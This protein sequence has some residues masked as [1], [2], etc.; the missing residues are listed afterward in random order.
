MS[1]LEAELSSQSE[2]EHN[3]TEKDLA[4]QTS[5][6]TLEPESMLEPE[7][8][9]TQN[10]E[11]EPM[12]ETTP[13]VEVIQNDNQEY[14]EKIQ[15]FEPLAFDQTTEHNLVQAQSQETLLEPE[16]M[17]EPDTEL[18]AEPKKDSVVA[19][20][21]STSITIS[22]SAPKAKTKTKSEK[23][24]ITKPTVKIEKNLKPAPTSMVD[25]ETK[26]T[27]ESKPEATAKHM[28][29][30]PKILNK[31]KI[32]V[33]HVAD[34]TKPK[35]EEDN[36]KSMP[37]LNM[38]AD[39]PQT[40]PATSG[41]GSS[42]S[43]GILLPLID[44]LSTTSQEMNAE[45]L[46]NIAPETPV[47]DKTNAA[48]LT[49][50]IDS[51]PSKLEAKPEKK[52]P[53]KKAMT[54][55]N[56]IAKPVMK[57]NTLADSHTPKPH[58]AGNSGEW[59]GEPIPVQS[60]NTTDSSSPVNANQQMQP[61]QIEES[62]ETQEQPAQVNMPTQQEVV[63]QEQVIVGEPFVSEQPMSPKQPAYTPK[64]V[65]QQDNMEH[66]E[67]VGEPR[68]VDLSA[69]IDQ[70]LEDATKSRR[71][72]VPP[73][74]LPNSASADPLQELLQNIDT[75]LNEAKDCFASANTEGVAVAVSSLI[76]HAETF[77]L[78]SLARLARPVEAAA[79]A[80]DMDALHDLFPELEIGV[81][82]NRI[83]LK[84]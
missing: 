43:D 80:S 21:K 82:R 56:K 45:Q 70:K 59:V 71:R 69:K 37:P 83:A 58:A 48:Y 54:I 74:P 6:P 77:G 64:H 63:F 67:Q 42:L 62:L 22:S 4:G 23:T 84:M 52:S 28:Q 18:P 31:P 51:S 12:P 13:K 61:S 32:R 79:K 7:I 57:Q 46:S 30:A 9:A 72:V 5:N 78:R 44:S 35:P 60:N 73:P 3:F 26:S 81:E 66:I 38:H 14:V 16:T 15:D 25:K 17:P 41:H 27:Q 11:P 49:S 55:V 75:S 24:I 2:F 8:M 76:Q 33:T 47:K 20:P 39:T 65:E 36:L 40:E 50:L 34:Q 68:P 53:L 10:V 19:E 1:T 29:P